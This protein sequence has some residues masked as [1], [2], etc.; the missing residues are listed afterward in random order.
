MKARTTIVA[1]AAKEN[2]IRTLIVDVDAGVRRNVV[3]ILAEHPAEVL[4]QESAHGL[5]AMSAVREFRPDILICEIEMPGIDGFALLETIPAKHRPSTIFLSRTDR[6]AARAFEVSA[7]DYVLKPLHP[8]RLFRAF[9]RARTLLEFSAPHTHHSEPLRS[10]RQLVIRSG[11]SM[12]FVKPQE[13]DWAEAE[14]KCVRLHM[15]KEFL[16]LKMSIS[17]LE[18]ELDP[19][20]FVRIHRSTLINVDRIRRVQ[21]WDHRRTYQVTLQDGTRLVLSRKSSLLEIGGK[22]IPGLETAS[23]L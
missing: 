21:P 6:F 23:S 8:D 2:P 4:I 13:L 15:G 12:I 14:G 5:E 7:T 1:N 17:A 11:R 9:E 16:T 22:T 3:E 10:M 19:A 20:Q 18:A